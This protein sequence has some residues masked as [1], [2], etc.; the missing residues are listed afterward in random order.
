MCAQKELTLW[1]GVWGP[2]GIP[3]PQFHSKVSLDSDG[4]GPRREGLS[5]V[6]ALQGEWSHQKLGEMI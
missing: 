4:E 1:V 6:W 3:N 5:H 2:V